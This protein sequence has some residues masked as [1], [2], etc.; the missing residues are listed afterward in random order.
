MGLLVVVLGACGSAADP[1]SA[2]PTNA[3]VGGQLAS[4]ATPRPPASVDPPDL[5]AGDRAY[6]TMD[7]LRVR[8]QPRIDPGTETGWPLLQRGM[9]VYIL[10]DAQQAD[11]YWWV[12]AEVGHYSNLACAESQYRQGAVGVCFPDEL[13]EAHEGWVAAADRDG[14]EWLHRW[15]P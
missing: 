14:T 2:S 13:G 7:D 3:I 4:P 10:G 8:S 9:V 11:G 1:T 12:H 15:A 5:R 6:V